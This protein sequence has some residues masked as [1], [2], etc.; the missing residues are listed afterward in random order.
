MR[1]CLPA[2]ARRV[3]ISTTS[4]TRERNL[5]KVDQ[6]LFLDLVF[7]KGREVRPAKSPRD[8]FIGRM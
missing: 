4:V 7:L 8:T 3:K 1:G 6:I 2:R 5:G